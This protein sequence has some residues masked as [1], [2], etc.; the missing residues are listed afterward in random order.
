MLLFDSKIRNLVVIDDLMSETDE[1]TVISLN[2]LFHAIT[3]TNVRVVLSQCA[4]SVA[5]R[6]VLP[7]HSAR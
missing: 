7:F 4:N 5:F 3:L 6:N 1:I 2:N